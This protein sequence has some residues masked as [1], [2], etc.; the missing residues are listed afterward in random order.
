LLSPYLAVVKLSDVLANAHAT[1]AAVAL[2][3]HVVA[4][5]QDDLRKNVGGAMAVRTATR[6]LWR[7]LSATVFFLLNAAHLLDL[8]RQLARWRKHEHLRL[9]VWDGK[10]QAGDGSD[11][12]EARTAKEGRSQRRE[13]ATEGRAQTQCGCK[14]NKALKKLNISASARPPAHPARPYRCVVSMDWRAAMEKVAVLPVPLCAWAMTSRP[15]TM[16]LI[17][18]CCTAEGFSKP[19]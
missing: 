15:L 11:K 3:I 18:R 14:A 12:E 8:R 1:D 7:W 10:K 17:A 4:E 16:G 9:A 6:G 13:L 2:H 19:A 5:R